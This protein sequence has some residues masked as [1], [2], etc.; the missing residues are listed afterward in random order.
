MNEP[1]VDKLA[2]V[3][4]RNERRLLLWSVAVQWLLLLL[5]ILYWCVHGGVFAQSLLW[6][7]L[8]VSLPYCWFAWYTFLTLRMDAPP[9]KKMQRL[10]RGEAQ[11]FV[12]TAVLAGAVFVKVHPLDA[13]GFF[14]AFVV[15]MVL[16]VAIP[17][18]LQHRMDS[19]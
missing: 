12:L 13:A 18:W 14:S 9:E 19:K 17:A 15:M 1:L 10:Y 3:E 6:G 8:A 2:A 16:G 7:A 4:R 11:K 5:L